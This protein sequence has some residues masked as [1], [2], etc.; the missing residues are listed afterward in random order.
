MGDRHIRV[1]TAASIIMWALGGGLVALAW[2]THD[3][4]FLGAGIY[5]ACVAGVLSI[6]SFI[7]EHET[8]MKVMQR[9][10]FE[11]GQDSVTHQRDVRRLH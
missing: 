3:S 2:P 10:W 4:W 8:S 6:R 9:N 11:L 5:F 7:L 1:C